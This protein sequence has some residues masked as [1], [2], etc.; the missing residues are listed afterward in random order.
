MVRSRATVRGLR[1]GFPCSLPGTSRDCSA[2]YT[3]DELSA[4]RSAL[5]SERRSADDGLVQ[6][7]AEQPPGALRVGQRG[8]GHPWLPDDR[9]GATRTVGTAVRRVGTDGRVPHEGARTTIVPVHHE[10]DEKDD[11]YS[12]GYEH[13]PPAANTPTGHPSQLEGVRGVSD[14]GPTLRP[15][16]P[17]TSLLTTGWSLSC[18][19]NT[20]DLGRRVVAKAAPRQ[21]PGMPPRSLC[22]EAAVGGVPR[23]D[24]AEDSHP[25]RS[26]PRVVTMDVR[27]TG[28]RHMAVTLPRWHH[29]ESGVLQ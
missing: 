8:L 21:P 25:C 17:W 9:R 18:G 14:H 29:D 1:G 5:S 3:P 26:R 23:A 28:L 6:A 11:H 10:G 20:V 16:R 19:A 24:P 12:E 27:S 7:E 13:R 22:P 2:S 15:W 4:C